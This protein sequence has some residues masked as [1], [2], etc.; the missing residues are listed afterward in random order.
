MPRWAG[1]LVWRVLLAIV[2][3]AAVAVTPPLVSGYRALCA[4][5]VDTYPVLAA[6][7]DGARTEAPSSLEANAWASVLDV[8]LHIKQ[9]DAVAFPLHV[10]A[11]YALEAGGCPVAS[12]ADQWRKAA[13]HAWFDSAAHLSANGLARTAGRLVGEQATR[14]RLERYAREEP[15]HAENLARVEA[16]YQQ[17]TR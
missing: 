10:A 11:G 13:G 14:E 3:I 5:P 16:V 4:E 9:S 6:T 7:R 12:S 17:P 1:I 8:F 15:W 2:L